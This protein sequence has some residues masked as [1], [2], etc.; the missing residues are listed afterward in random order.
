MWLHGDRRVGP[1]PIGA[2]HRVGCNLPPCAP[3]IKRRPW[4]LELVVRH[5]PRDTVPSGG[6][7]WAAHAI[8][9]LGDGKPRTLAE[10]QLLEQFPDAHTPRV[11]N[12]ASTAASS[13]TGN[14]E[15]EGDGENDG[16]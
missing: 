10:K 13:S 4:A 12:A 16:N 1:K 7:Q 14:D 11:S 3:I 6:P 15:I 8:R 5:A 2:A 9:Q